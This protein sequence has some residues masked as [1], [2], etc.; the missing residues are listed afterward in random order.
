MKLSTSLEF[1]RNMTL[2]DLLDLLDEL[3]EIQEEG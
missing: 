3:I 2:M 1:L